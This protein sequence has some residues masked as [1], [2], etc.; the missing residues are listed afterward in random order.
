MATYWD[1]IKDHKRRALAYGLSLL[2]NAA[3]DPSA[4]EDLGM[5]SSHIGSLAR[6]LGREFGFEERKELLDRVD[7]Q[8]SQIEELEAKIEHLNEHDPNNCIDCVIR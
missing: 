7:A 5:T 6:E 2:S 1:L 3:D 4:Q 8:K